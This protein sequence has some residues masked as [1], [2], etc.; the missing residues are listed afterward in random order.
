MRIG[1]LV[2]LSAFALGF[3]ACNR[4]ETEA[5]LKQ[6]QQKNSGEYIVTL[7][8]QTGQLQQGSANLVLEFRRAADQQ[9]V[10]VGQVSIEAAMPMS[11]MPDMTVDTTVTPAGQPGR[12]NIGTNFSM[13]GAYK[14]IVSFAENQRVQFDVQAM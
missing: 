12:Y 14:I 6:I 7:L 8:N 4:T 2:V 13:A 10:D 1:F 3:V 9:G 5:G 11:G